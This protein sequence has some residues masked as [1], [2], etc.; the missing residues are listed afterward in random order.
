MYAL[1]YIR[2]FIITIRPNEFKIFELENY[3]ILSIRNYY[4]YTYY[5]TITR[6]IMPR[7]FI[8]EMVRSP[9]ITLSL[10]KYYN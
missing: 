3:N 5:R 6:L 2:L 4:L 7:I 1:Y 9:D 10:Q 8:N